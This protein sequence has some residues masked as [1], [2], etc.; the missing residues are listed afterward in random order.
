[1]CPQLVASI[2]LHTWVLTLWNRVKSYMVTILN[3]WKMFRRYLLNLTHSSMHSHSKRAPVRSWIIVPFVLV[4]RIS[5][6]QK[7]ITSFFSLWMK[8]VEKDGYDDN[9]SCRKKSFHLKIY[10]FPV[11]LHA[12]IALCCQCTLILN[13]IHCYVFAQVF[14]GP[15]GEVEEY[16]VISIQQNAA[17][18]LDLILDQKEEHLFIMTHNMV[19]LQSFRLLF[20]PQFFLF[21]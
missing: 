9:T 2:V 7:Q 17:I 13:P 3:H 4:I 20:L 15:N 1:M 18:S 16:S 8:I 10:C 21:H 5:S 6:P 19:I 11:W 12:L 14:L